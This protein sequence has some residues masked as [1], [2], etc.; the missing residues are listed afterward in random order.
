MNFNNLQKN[1]RLETLK[2]GQVPDLSEWLPHIRTFVPK[3]AIYVVIYNGYITE[4]TFLLPD[5][6]AWI[7][8]NNDPIFRSKYFHQSK[9]DSNTWILKDEFRTDPAVKILLTKESTSHFTSL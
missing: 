2:N 1:F 7:N 4:A 8:T 3:M 5:G 9:Y 6:I